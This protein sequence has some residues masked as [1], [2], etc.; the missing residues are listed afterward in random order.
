MIEGEEAQEYPSAASSPYLKSWRLGVVIAS[1]YLGALLIALDTN[2]INVAIPHISTEFASLQD[3]SWYGT[4]Y[5]LTI[6]AFQPAFGTI[7]KFFSVA[8]TYRTCVVLFE[9][10]LLEILF[11]TVGLTHS[12]LSS[13]L[14]LLRYG[15]Q[16]SNVHRRKSYC[17]LWSRRNLARSFEYSR[18]GSGVG[19]AAI[20]HGHCHQCFYNLRLHWASS[21]WGLHAACNMEMVFL[22]V[23]QSKVGTESALIFGIEISL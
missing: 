11:T 7:Y 5:L 23:S 4:A 3:V 15:R 18:T 12:L 16:F 6:T 20:I 22:D 10:T 8:T 2:I 14:D 9:G 1:L 17:R 19:E 13:R 21:R